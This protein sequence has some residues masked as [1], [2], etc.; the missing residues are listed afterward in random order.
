[1]T[2]FLILGF[3]INYTILGVS[4]FNAQSAGVRIFQQ[5]L[6]FLLLALWLVSVLRRD[7]DQGLP[8]TRLNG[9]LL[10]LGFAWLVAAFAAIDPRTSIEYTWPIISCGADTVHGCLKRC[11]SLARWSW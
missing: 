6:T 10:A 1:M 8:S 7:Q 9:P 11:F 5:V 2:R 4:F 3:T